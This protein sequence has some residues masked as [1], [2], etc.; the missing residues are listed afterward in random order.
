MSPCVCVC[1]CVSVYFHWFTYQVLFK[2]VCL[3]V[4]QR[5][6]LSI[7]VGEQTNDYQEIAAKDKLSDLQLRVR[8][9]LD[10]AEQI[11][12]EQNY[13]RVCMHWSLC[14]HCSVVLMFWFWGIVLKSVV[15]N[16]KSVISSLYNTLSQYKCTARL[17]TL[18]H[19]VVHALFWSFRIFRTVLL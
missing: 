2:C 7:D 5:V 1:V 11:S 14:L 19:S 4:C 6:H 18:L 10:Q 17:V 12:K 3:C 8:Q 15:S 9:L 13:Q 16:F